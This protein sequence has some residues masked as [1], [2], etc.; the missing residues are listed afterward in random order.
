MR[1]SSVTGVQTCAIPIY[2]VEA[3]YNDDMRRLTLNSDAEQHNK[4]SV[5]RAPAGLE[6]KPRKRR[7]GRTR[8]EPRS[9]ASF[10]QT[11]RDLGKLIPTLAAAGFAAAVLTAPASAA[12]ISGAGATF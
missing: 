9:G 10:R 6:R 2:V 12:D 7:S 11:W 8:R 3:S 4:T 1:D 5:I